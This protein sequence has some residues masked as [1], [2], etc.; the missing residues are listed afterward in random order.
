MNKENL[1]RMADH[2]RTI[3]QEKFGM[4]YYRRGDRH[5]AECNSLG[6]VLGHCTVLDSGELPRFSNG[7]IDFIAWE[8]SFT[9][10]TQEEWDWCFSGNWA[11]VDDTSEGASLRIEWLIK[12]GLPEDYLDQL[13]GDTEICYK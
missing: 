10:T 7:S 8:E 6:C 9:G 12:N 1:Q 2:I 4:A 5:T 13:I 3:P 11:E